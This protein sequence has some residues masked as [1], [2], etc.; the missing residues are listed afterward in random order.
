MRISAIFIQCLYLSIFILSGC[1]SLPN[2]E[3]YILNEATIQKKIEALRPN[4]VHIETVSKAG[5][6]FYGFGFIV[7][8]IWGEDE[9]TI[10]IVTAN[11][12]IRPKEI[13]QP[14]SKIKKIKVMFYSCR[15]HGYVNASSILNH[16]DEDRDFTVLKVDIEQ[17]ENVS[18]FYQREGIHKP[19]WKL[20]KFSS[21]K[22]KEPVWFIGLNGEWDIPA[23]GVIKN[24]DTKKTIEINIQSVMKGTS[25]APLI[26]QDG[27]IV[28]LITLDEEASR[29]QATSIDAIKPTIRRKWNL[30]FDEII[31]DLIPPL[32]NCDPEEGPLEQNQFSNKYGMRFVRIKSGCFDMGVPEDRIDRGQ[33][34]LPPHNVC[35]GN[36]FY[37]QKT[38]ITHCQWE[39]VMGAQQAYF[40]TCGDHCPVENV[41]WR[42]VQAFIRKLNETNTEYKYR[43]PS[44]KEWEYACRLR[45]R[46]DYPWG[47]D[48]FCNKMMY[49]NGPQGKCR[50]V[51]DK[52]NFESSPVKVMTFPLDQNQ[53]LQIYDMNGNVREWC[54]D[55]MRDAP[56]LV[57]GNLRVVRGGGWNSRASFCRC[58]A[59]D[60]VHE[61]SIRSSSIGFR[62]VAE[63]ND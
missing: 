26:N 12:T 15:G 6:R 53:S 40:S 58:G 62:L 21:P 11:H 14:G 9:K 35:I 8:E 22:V 28:G 57:S 29:S 31:D 46:T 19:T 54:Q 24:I 34:D 16:M 39:A 7:G 37:I 38:E 63:L 51:F 18:H 43:L 41:S 42:Q 4:V 56:S 20:G 27:E 52:I 45:T 60:G 30:P 50:E 23:H 55:I 10:L 2:N 44:E 61:A 59:R 5:H 47:D 32:P 25:G 33:Y 3:N 1:K 17:C 13:D 48:A 36:D 49:E